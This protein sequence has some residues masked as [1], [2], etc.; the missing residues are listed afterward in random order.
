[1]SYFSNRNL[2]VKFNKKERERFVEALSSFFREEHEKDF[3]M[4]E[5]IKSLEVKLYRNIHQ[6]ITKILM[7]LIDIYRK[8]FLNK[9]CIY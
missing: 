2:S 8:G 4:D 9:N 1:M 7:L 6:N 5:S 3:H